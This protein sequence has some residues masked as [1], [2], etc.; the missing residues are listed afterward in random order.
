MLPRPW[1]HLFCQPLTQTETCSS[2]SEPE[3]NFFLTTHK[4]THT[5]NHQLFQY[6]QIQRKIESRYTKHCLDTNRVQML[7]FRGSD[8]NSHTYKRESLT[9]DMTSSTSALH[10][11]VGEVENYHCC[12][13]LLWLLAI[14]CLLAPAI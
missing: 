10:V 4:H 6:M 2:C 1:R 8:K 12:G 5:H 9:S 3:L 14:A 7:M 13:N 11:T